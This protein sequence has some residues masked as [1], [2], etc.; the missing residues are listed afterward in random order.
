MATYIISAELMEKVYGHLETLTAHLPKDE[1]WETLSGQSQELLRVLERTIIPLEAV[2]DEEIQVLMQRAVVEESHEIRA[3]I[4]VQGDV[5][6]Y[7]LDIDDIADRWP[8]EESAGMRAAAEAACA[9]QWGNIQDGKLPL[10]PSVWL[11]A[12]YS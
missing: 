9:W 6:W 4:G 3:A 1:H 2:V 12:A 8:G 5:L 7:N 10:S 11:D